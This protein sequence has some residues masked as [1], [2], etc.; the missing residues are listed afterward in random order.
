MRLRQVSISLTLLLTSL[1]HGETQPQVCK[2][3]PWGRIEYQT[4][5]LEAPSWVVDHFPMPSTQ[6]PI[7]LTRKPTANTA[8]VL[9][10]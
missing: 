7:G 2:P 5:Y 8:A 6:P 10:S 4:I 3:G 1:L 9:S